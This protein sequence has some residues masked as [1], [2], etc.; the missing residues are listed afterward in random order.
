MIKNGTQNYKANKGYI[1]KNQLP[2]FCQGQRA[3]A[4]CNKICFNM[5]KE[6]INMNGNKMNMIM[7]MMRPIHGPPIY[8]YDLG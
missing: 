3:I 8:L 2:N 4:F 6:K 7:L 1:Q 5:N